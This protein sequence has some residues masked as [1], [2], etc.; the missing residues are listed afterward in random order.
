MMLIT[1]TVLVVD[2]LRGS[3]DS[4]TDLRFYLLLGGTLAGI[5]VAGF[6]AWGLLGPI[7]S[8]YRRGGLA[9]VCAFATVLVM[10]VCIPINQ[11]F[12]R[13]G[14]GGLLAGFGLAAAL[15]GRRALRL[16]SQAS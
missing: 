13:I 11:W 4:N 12:G 15:L 5:M 14:L 3:G 10:L 8:L 16:R 1:A 7:N 6:A 2:A 9:M